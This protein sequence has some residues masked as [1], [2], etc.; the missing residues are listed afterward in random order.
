MNLDEKLEDAMRD[1]L[2]RYVEEYEKLKKEGKVGKLDL[3]EYRIDPTNPK[4][5]RII[6]RDLLAD[7]LSLK[8]AK[9]NNR[10]QWIVGIFTVAIAISTVI[11]VA[12]LLNLI[13]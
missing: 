10:L 3:L 1:H 9:S 13:P 12:K 11:Q 6:D 8:V 2:D 4:S 5:K 7:Y